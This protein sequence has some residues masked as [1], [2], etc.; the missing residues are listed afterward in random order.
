MSADTLDP[1]I[2]AFRAKKVKHASIDIALND[3][4]RLIKNPRPESVIVLI[5]PSG[6]GKTTVVDA[7]KR[8]LIE[9]YSEEIQSD[10]GFVPFISINTPTPLDGNFNWKDL[11]TRMLYAG[12]EVLIQYKKLS[13]FEIELDGETRSSTM[14]LAREEL[15]RSFES[16]VRHRHVRAIIL[17]EAS[18]I[19]R[20]KSGLKPLLSFE[21]L[22]SLAVEFK[23]PIILI[24]AYDL[25]GVLEG[26][27]QLLRRSDVIHLRRYAI[28]RTTAKVPDEERFRDVLNAFLEKIQIKQDPNLL[29]HAD[30]FFTKSVGCVGV[31]KDWLDR[32]L[33][34]AL[35]RPEP[36]LTRG[37]IE[38][39][40]LSNR[41][42]M[43]LVEEAIA[44]ELRLDDCND[45]E[46]AGA[47]GLKYTPSIRLV[48]PHVSTD[49]LINPKKRKGRVAQRGPSRDVV[50]GAHA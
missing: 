6:A 11:F 47:L 50:G 41:K 38:T 5:G 14:G 32:A 21:I 42:L 28:G 12:G 10:P 15:R 37:I 39:Q 20:L 1:R 25:L 9:H 24:G 4:L 46:L 34:D 3:L 40:A 45:E 29:D 36:V 35:S 23:V 26:S 13:R 44:G 17:D 33:V 48:A 8:R 27:G 22:K 30:Y 18:A 2:E 19:L 43:R 16:M 31:L 7:L 49:E